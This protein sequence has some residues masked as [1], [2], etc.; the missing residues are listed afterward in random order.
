[1]VLVRSSRLAIHDRRRRVHVDPV[2]STVNPEEGNG[3]G[4]D[5]SQ[6][7]SRFL[8]NKE[9]DDL[10]Q[11]A[12]AILRVRSREVGGRMDWFVLRQIFP[13]VPRNS[14]RQRISSLKEPQNNEVYMRR[15]EDQWYRLWK[16]YRGTEHLPDPNPQSQTDFDLIKHLQFLRKFV[17]KNALYVLCYLLYTK[18]DMGLETSRFPRNVD[19]SDAARN[20]LSTTLIVGRPGQTGQHAVLGFSVGFKG[21]RKPR[22]GTPADGIHNQP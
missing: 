7:K 4:D 5:Q 6:R 16:Q 2:V 21:R 1:M 3:E 12:H 13:A 11:D 22:E 19:D 10:V 18:A 17:D 20:G 8:W 14:L 15:L 9:Y